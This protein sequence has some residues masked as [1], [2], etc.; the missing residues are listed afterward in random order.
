[1]ASPLQQVQEK[2]K[3]ACQKS[4]RPPNEIT[5]LAVSKKKSPDHLYRVF[6]EGQYIFGESYLQEATEKIAALKKMTENA[7]E[8]PQWHFIGR[9]QSK[10]SA[11]ISEMFQMIHSLDNIKHAEKLNDALKKKEKKLPTLIQVNTDDEESKGG[12]APKNLFPFLEACTPLQALEV[13]GLMCIP[14]PEKQKKDPARAF[15]RLR[16]LLEQANQAHCYKRKLTELSM[17]MSADFE[18]AIQE[19]STIIRLGEALFGPREKKQ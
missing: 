11:Q 9:L 3:N 19:G 16:Q 8:K 6:Q 2:I 17:G 14:S 7:H 1:M 5:L 13:K 4:G 18:A 12:I 15:A 10:K